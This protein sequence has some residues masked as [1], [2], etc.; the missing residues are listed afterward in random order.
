MSHA[1]VLFPY[2]SDNHYVF[3][4]FTKT[5][6]PQF[7][8]TEITVPRVFNDFLWLRKL[9]I[10]RYPYL[11]IPHLP[12]SSDIDNFPQL[13]INYLE[14]KRSDLETFIQRIALHTILSTCPEVTSFLQV[15]NWQTEEQSA[16]FADFFKRLQADAGSMMEKLLPPDNQVKGEVLGFYEKFKRHAVNINVQFVT[17]ESVLSKM[18]KLN[19]EMSPSFSL[20]SSAVSNLS[21]YDTELGA[22]FRSLGKQLSNLGSLYLD[23]VHRRNYYT[24]SE[25]SFRQITLVQKC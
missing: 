1:Q 24:Y 15:K 7:L 19:K 10:S 13:S 6:L 17:L 18:T 12:G 23:Q 14:R 3:P 8:S 2:H 21:S 22:M 9:L 11:I 5:T 16:A 20:M 25:T 4:V